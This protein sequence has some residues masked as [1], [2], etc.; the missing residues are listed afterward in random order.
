VDSALASS[1][2]PAG[3]GLRDASSAELAGVGPGEACSTEPAAVGLREVCPA[4]PSGV[5][6]PIST[7][8]ASSCGLLMQEVVEGD[9]LT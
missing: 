3:V 7:A 4:E 5:A 2:E 6:G 8:C 1:A 9:T